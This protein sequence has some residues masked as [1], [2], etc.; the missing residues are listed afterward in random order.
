MAGRDIDI[1]RL[2]APTKLDEVGKLFVTL[3]SWK[4][5]PVIEHFKGSVSYTEAK[6][7][8]AYMRQAK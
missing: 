1:N 8:R 2:I 5:T 4:L 3:Q 6:V 7:A